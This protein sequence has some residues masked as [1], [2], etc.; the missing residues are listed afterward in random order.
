M[1]VYIEYN[2]W[3]TFITSVLNR[4][5]CNPITHPE[6]ITKIQ[7]RVVDSLEQPFDC[8]EEEG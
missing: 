5:H 1:Y 3:G 8:H 4:S 6:I 2:R 7:S